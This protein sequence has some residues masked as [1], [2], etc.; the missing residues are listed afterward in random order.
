MQDVVVTDEFDPLIIAAFRAQPAELSVVQAMRRAIRSA[1]ES[2]SG[3]EL[4]E[5]TA[6]PEADVVGS[7]DRALAFLQDG[8]PLG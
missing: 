6:D 2:L 5:W 4:A 3:E 1:A 8:L 7:I